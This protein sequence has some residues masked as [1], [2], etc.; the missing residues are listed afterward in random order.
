MEPSRVLTLLSDFGLSDPYVGVMKGAIAQVNAS[1]TVIDLTHQIP[2]Q[3]IA[4]ARFALM[5]AY[6]YFPA[7]AVHVAVVDPGVGGT[8]RAIAVAIG[9]MA[10]PPTG[11]LVGPDNGIFSGVF[12][13]HPIIA[14]VSLTNSHYWRTP[15]PSVTFHGRDIFAPVGA[16]LASGVLLTEMGDRL[17]P[18]TLV[19]LNVPVYRR[20]E[21]CQLE[22]DS[23]ET[24][25]AVLA[26]GGDVACSS[27]KLTG[28]IQAIDHFG[29]VITNIPEAQVSG[30]QWSLSINNVTLPGQH[31]YS[32]SLPGELLALVGSHGWVEVA[33]NGGNAQARLHLNRELAANRIEIVISC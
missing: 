5:T 31:T 19:R 16:H 11:F 4:L 13:A 28:C 21:N 20:L 6:P 3:D 14:A 32:D 7:G 33:V 9:E 29:N 2:P 24:P 23:I 27:Y 15:A 8:R 30:K 17:E 18:E 12:A 26:E 1:L 25:A 10:A 22:A